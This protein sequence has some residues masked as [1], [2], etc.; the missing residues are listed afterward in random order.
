MFSPFELGTVFVKTSLRNPPRSNMKP[1]MVR[2]VFL[3]NF[4]TKFRVGLG[5]PSVMFA[6]LNLFDVSSPLTLHVPPNK[7]LERPCV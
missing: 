6:P 7:L 5:K 1:N 2:L 3:L 4:F